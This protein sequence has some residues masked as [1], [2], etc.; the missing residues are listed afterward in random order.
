MAGGQTDYNPA[1]LLQQLT[2]WGEQSQEMSSLASQSQAAAITGV[3][4]GIFADAVSAYNSC[5][6]EMQSLF[7]QGATQMQAISTALGVAA[8]KYGANES[9]I[10]AASAAAR[11][12]LPNGH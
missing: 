2:Q 3:D 1:G 10:A 11:S 8:K 9:Q 12:C 5:V 4:A 7:T 6:Q